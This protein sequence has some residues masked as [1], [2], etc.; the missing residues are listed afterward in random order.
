MATFNR[1]GNMSPTPEINANNF[2]LAEKPFKIIGNIYYVGNTHA[3]SILIDSGEGLILLDTPSWPE[4]AYLLDA[5]YTL[6]FNPRDIKY[7]VVS[8]SH[9]DH[10]G[11]AQALKYMYGCKTFIGR[12]DAEY[13]QA[14]KEQIEEMGRSRG[15]VTPWP[16]FDVLLEDGDVIELGNVKM[17]CVLTPGHTVGVMSHFWETEE[18]GKTYKVGIYGG[19][20]FV[21]VGTEAIKRNGLP[22]SIQQD[23]WDSID[24]V[25]DE[26]VDVMLG[27]HPFHNDTFDKNERRVPGGP[28]PF[29]DP[30]EWKRYLQ[31]L[32]DRYG[33]FLKLTPEEVAE[34]YRGNGFFDYRPQLLERYEEYKAKY[35]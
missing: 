28:N 12:V 25:W 7:V 17:R 14:H 32:R 15:S 29:A 9:A 35:L 10:Y 30:T 23:F 19:A 2:L 24:K 11:C 34:M 13:M 3:S 5:I 21:T 20:G 31:E 16:H 18:D 4:Y 8:H 1:F 6:G 26:E 22:M 33:E 27:N